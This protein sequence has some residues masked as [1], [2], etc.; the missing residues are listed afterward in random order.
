MNRQNRRYSCWDY[1]S[2]RIIASRIIRNSDF[3]SLE[4]IRI[5]EYQLDLHNSVFKERND[6]AN[7]IKQLKLHA[8]ASPLIF[9]YV[10]I[11]NLLL[12][13]SSKHNFYSLERNKM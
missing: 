5:F 12:F 8:S 11:Y 6:C 2:I 7:P 9:M 1:P 4:Q 3:D 10:Q 13:L